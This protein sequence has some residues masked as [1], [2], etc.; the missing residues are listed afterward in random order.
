[1]LVINV[2]VGVNPAGHHQGGFDVHQALTR[3]QNVHV[4]HHAPER[5]LQ[6]CQGVG[7][8][9]EQHHGHADGLQGAR[10]LRHLKAQ[11]TLLARHQRQC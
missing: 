11:F 7:T 4:G 5:C 3:H 2:M 9:L 6:A 10:Y 1:M 8:S